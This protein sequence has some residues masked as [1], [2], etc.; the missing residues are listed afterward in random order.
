MITDMLRTPIKSVSLLSNLMKLIVQHPLSSICN[1]FDLE[2]QPVSSILDPIQ[3]SQTL[4]N[5]SDT[6]ITVSATY[7]D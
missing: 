2:E 1:K 5:N 6:S 7:M 4:G 3:I